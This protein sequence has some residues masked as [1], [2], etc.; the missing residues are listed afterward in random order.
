MHEVVGDTDKDIFNGLAVSPGLCAPRATSPPS[1]SATIVEGRVELDLDHDEFDRLDE[2]GEMPP[3]AEIRPTRPSCLAA[4]ST[5]K[6]ALRDY[7]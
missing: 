6:P 2:H 5:G 3:S 4:A 7:P 1:A